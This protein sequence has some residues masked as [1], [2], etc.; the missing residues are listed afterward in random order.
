[1]RVQVLRRLSVCVFSMRFHD[2]A[3]MLQVL[4]FRVCFWS[5]GV[6]SKKKLS[7]ARN[8]IIGDPH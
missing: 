6:S 1:M 7:A 2:Y 5:S 3:N 4:G 8:D